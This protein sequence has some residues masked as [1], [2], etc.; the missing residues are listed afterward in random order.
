MR[1]LFSLFVI[2]ASVLVIFLYKLPSICNK[3]LSYRIGTIDP[4]FQ[5]TE[6]ELK[7]A[8][9]DA[10]Y[11][12]ERAAKR[13]LF[14]EKPLD[15][16]A[17]VISM[18]YD[19]RQQYSSS[20]E[21]QTDK[22]KEEKQSLDPQLQAYKADEEEFKQRMDAFNKKVEEWNASDHTN[23]A[24]YNALYEEK[25]RLVEDSKALE[26]RARELNQSTATYNQDVDKLN[27]SINQFQ[28][29]LQAKPEEGLYDGKT[30]TISIYYNTD[31][32]ELLHTIAHELGHA[33]GMDHVS[34]TEAIM[35]AKTNKTLNPTID[36]IAEL[37]KVC[38]SKTAYETLRDRDWDQWFKNVSAYIQS[39]LHPQD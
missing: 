2:L 28:S 25:N 12:W 7:T 10:G 1:K 18:I 14:E 31:R 19:E 11:S 38:T 36:D 8:I 32:T 9:T 26:Q 15:D 23:E 34:N 6:D 22:L 3:P 5:M 4:Q 27:L 29:V 21:N 20:V 16:K 37:T 39:N 30:N 35:F 17:I 24:D 13:D 33:L